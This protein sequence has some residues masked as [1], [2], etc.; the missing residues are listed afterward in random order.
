MTT[1][2]RP[3]SPLFEQAMRLRAEGLFSLPAV[4]ARAREAGPVFWRD[5]AALAPYERSA[6]ARPT[7]VLDFLGQLTRRLAPGSV[8]DPYAT[9]PLPLAA[10]AE[11]VPGARLVAAAADPA[12]RDIGAALTPSADWSLDPE[13]LFERTQG[14]TFD[15]VLL[16]PPLGM[17]ARP[18][19]LPALPALSRPELADYALLRSLDR[20]APGGRIIYHCADNLF[21]GGEGQVLAACA[22]RGWHLTAAISVDRGFWPTTS[23]QSSIAVFEAQPTEQLFVARLDERTATAALVAN[24]LARRP[25][26]VNFHLGLLTDRSYRSWQ[27]LVVQRELADAFRADELIALATVG[28]LR[29]VTLRAN[30]DYEPPDNAVFVPGIGMGDV[31]TYP[32]TYEGRSGYRLLEVQLDPDRARAE[33]VAALLSSPI[34][35]R[36]R[37]VSSRG[38]TLPHVDLAALSS[39]RIPLPSLI[40]QQEAIAAAG[41]LASMEATVERLRSDLWRRPEKAKRVV[42]QLEQAAR[43]DPVRRW[44]ESM[45]Y[46]LASVLQRYVALRDPE[47]RVQSL[48]NFFEAM[49]QF[50]CAVLLSVFRADDVLFQQVQADLAKAAPPGRQLFDRA[51]FGLWRNLGTTLAKNVRRLAGDKEHQE[52]FEAASGPAGVL[53]ERLADK[54]FWALLD[55]ARVVR[56]QRSHGGVVSPEQLSGWLSG[57]ESLLSD[58]EQALGTAFEDVDL[59]LAAEG[60]YRHGLYTYHQAERLR[61]PSAIFQQFEVQTR[62]PLE[63]DH[64]TFVSRDA[65]VSPVLHLVPLV[66]V[67]PTPRSANNACYFF[68]SR[69][70]GAISYVSYHFEGEPRVELHDDDLEDLARQ[71]AGQPD[72]P[73]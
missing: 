63:S 13:A 21:W 29:A 47:A 45:P 10:V 42:E 60:R 38:S 20:A 41:H 24:L 12:V 8:L 51:D 28:R 66:R 68:E 23:L 52:A 40:A 73:A 22:E 44:L 71:V 36:L 58:V 14:Q 62:Q 9:S 31:T 39:V 53:I 33:Y 15:V 4:V 61:G 67:G 64:L 32:P 35:K 65:A 30:R 34:G 37:E 25:D 17:R 18:A 49:A 43:L 70:G 16:S 59:A 6:V 54:R 48:V 69:Q 2:R 57:L 50:G 7:H 19:Q 56:N 1:A 55:R 27:T 26:T 46:P 3:D 5:V 72:A 11:A